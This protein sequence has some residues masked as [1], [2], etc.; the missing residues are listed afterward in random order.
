MH[1]STDVLLLSD[2]DPVTEY[3]AHW[4]IMCQTQIG[5]QPEKWYAIH[6][7]IHFVMT[8]YILNWPLT[9]MMMISYFSHCDDDGYRKWTF[10]IRS[11]CVSVASDAKEQQF[12]MNQ[13]QACARRHS[14]S[15]AKVCT[16]RVHTHTLQS[17][18][19]SSSWNMSLRKRAVQWQWSL[20]FPLHLYFDFFIWP[21]I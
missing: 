15:S 13:L 8:T 1:Y 9:R 3:T 17:L 5:C 18:L 10:L 21:F 14:D 20:D 11:F 16:T 6:N 19:S 2:R 4:L 12:W 7:D